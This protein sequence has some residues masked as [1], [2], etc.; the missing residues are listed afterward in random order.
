MATKCTLPAV[1]LSNLIEIAFKML[2]EQFFTTLVSLEMRL[3]MKHFESFMEG[4]YVLSE[5]GIVTHRKQLQKL[6]HL[7]SLFVCL[8]CLFWPYHRVK[9]SSISVSGRIQSRWIVLYAL[10]VIAQKLAY[11]DSICFV[12]LE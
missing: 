5:N 3:L 9:V 4:F 10:S 1:N 7:T 12:T 11:T 2:N 8:R 6:A